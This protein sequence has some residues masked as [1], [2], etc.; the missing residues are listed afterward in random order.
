MTGRIDNLVTDGLVL[1]LEGDV[2][3]EVAPNRSTF[4]FPSTLSNGQSYSVTIVR[5]PQRLGCRIVNGAGKLQGANVTNVVVDCTYR[6]SCAA[7]HD[8]MPS[9]STGSYIVRPA[10]PPFVVHCDMSFYDGLRK[11]DGPSSCRP[12]RGTGPLL[13]PR[14]K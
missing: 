12:A 2:S 14:A 7:L 10:D 8:D 6:P 11:E 3:L 4:T 13:C 9:L 1:A 5:Q